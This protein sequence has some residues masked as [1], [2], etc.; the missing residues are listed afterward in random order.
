M[1]DAG[2]SFLI[3]A[4]GTGERLGLGPKG[5]LELQG[6]PLLC[7]LADKALQVAGEVL[8]AVPAGSI[9]AVAAMLPGCRVIAGG[10]TRHA[11]VARLAQAACG[12]WLL[13]HDAARPFASV[14]LFRA[15]LEAARETGCAATVLDPE[16]P[17][18]R[19]RDGLLVEA[20]PPSAMG[21]SQ[22]PQA[23]SR[24]AMHRM[25]ALAAEH[26]WQPQSTMQLALF[27]GERVRAVRGEKT[28][29]K[30]TTRED[31]SA[32]QHLEDLLQ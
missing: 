8:V 21:V 30:I 26:G 10:A 17:V 12:D 3:P 13:L 9:E 16:V 7:W 32:V 29:I 19:I 6:R 24:Q 23:F 22:T 31:W 4:A 18:A 28:N 25:Q 27:A 14:A 15:A 11:S 20:H 2:V 5:F 1:A